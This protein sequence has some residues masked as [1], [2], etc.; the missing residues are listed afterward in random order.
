MARRQASSRTVARRE[1]RGSL[2]EA[3][4]HIGTNSLIVVCAEF[5]FRRSH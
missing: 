1:V 2:Q 3:T 4:D 5:S